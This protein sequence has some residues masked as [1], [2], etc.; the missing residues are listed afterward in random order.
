MDILRFT[1]E[2]VWELLEWMPVEITAL[3]YTKRFDSIIVYYFRNNNQELRT[4]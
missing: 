4:G 1:A 2:K 3:G